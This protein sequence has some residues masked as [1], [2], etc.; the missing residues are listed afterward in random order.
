M[1]A[2]SK[3]ATSAPA[4]AP[5]EGV[6]VAPPVPVEIN[7]S[8][9]E[10]RHISLLDMM[11][12]HYKTEPRR[13]IKINNSDHDV[14]VQVNGYTFVIQPKV[15]VKVPESIAVLLEDAGYI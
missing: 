8:E 11:K 13:E 15:K 2:R 9:A 1:P 5:E 14:S 7:R 6:E 10:Q 12:A 4:P 3:T